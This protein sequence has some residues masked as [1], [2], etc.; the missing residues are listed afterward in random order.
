MG[1]KV[2]IF[3]ESNF[4]NN[5]TE[6]KLYEIFYSLKMGINMAIEEA[7]GDCNLIELKARK[8]S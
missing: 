4:L 5:E 2:V 8:I 7:I 6:S 3:P 1:I